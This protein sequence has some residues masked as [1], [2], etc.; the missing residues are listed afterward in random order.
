[1]LEKWVE[2]AEIEQRVAQL[3]REVRSVPEILDLQARVNESR[4]AALLAELDIIKREVR[5]LPRILAEM[6]H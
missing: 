1:V 3:E 2:M 4:F 5:A 6:P